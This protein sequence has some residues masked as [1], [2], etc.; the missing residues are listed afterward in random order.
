ML[1]VDGFH[2]ARGILNPGLLQQISE[3]IDRHPRLIE[4]LGSSRNARDPY[5][6]S[7]DRVMNLWRTVRPIAELIYSRELTRPSIDLLGCSRLRLSHD[8]CLYKLPHGDPTPIH[9]DQYHWPVSSEKTLTAWIPLQPTP[10]EMGPV[11][12]YKGSHLIDEAQRCALHESQQ[13]AIDAFF[14][15]GP[16]PLIEPE[17]ALG[18]V[19]FHYGWTFH[20][21]GANQS[22]EIRKVVTIVYMEDGIRL[23]KMRPEQHEKMLISWCPGRSFG[24]LLDSPN[25][26][27]VAAI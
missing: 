3:E 18:D 12:F 4:V 6:R 1:R 25:N 21:A 10:K 17:F 23:A 16:F 27:L 19:S 2:V 7:F 24:D 14:L 26:P 11:R 5:L 13:E 9:A 22:D 15:K 20:S 8:Q